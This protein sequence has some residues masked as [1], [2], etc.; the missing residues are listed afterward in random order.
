MPVLRGITGSKRRKVHR[1]VKN[2]S[3]LRHTR[4]P[5]MV[6][7]N[8]CVFSDALIP[9]LLALEG[10]QGGRTVLRRH[11]CMYV[12]IGDAAEFMDIDSAEDA[13]R[14]GGMTDVDGNMAL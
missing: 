13:G 4:L 8:P 3:P 5:V 11:R 2:S 14:I 9:E 7:G 6:V 10:D 1:F 12:E